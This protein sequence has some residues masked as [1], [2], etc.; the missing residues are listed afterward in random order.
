MSHGRTDQRT[1]NSHRGVLAC[2]G[3]TGE[4]SSSSRASSCLDCPALSGKKLALSLYLHPLPPQLKSN[5]ATEWSSTCVCIF[6]SL[7]CDK[8]LIEGK[9]LE[10]RCVHTASD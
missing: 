4:I 5:P 7:F 3:D 6:L 10:R 2:S 9:S 1:A 8:K